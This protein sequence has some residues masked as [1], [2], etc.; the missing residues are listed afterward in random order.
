MSLAEFGMLFKKIIWHLGA[1]RQLCRPNLPFR[2]A[3]A[4]FG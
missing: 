4:F 1:L 3:D 2:P